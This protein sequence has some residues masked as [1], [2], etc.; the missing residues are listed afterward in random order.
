MLLFC[1]GLREISYCNP[2]G[3]SLYNGCSRQDCEDVWDILTL[4]TCIILRPLKV[5]ILE[6]AT[7]FK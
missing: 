2:Q 6:N 5:A 7:E 4:L 3:R 1:R